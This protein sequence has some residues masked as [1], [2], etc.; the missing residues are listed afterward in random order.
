MVKAGS[1]VPANLTELGLVVLDGEVLESY[2][3]LTGV[4]E[5]KV[6]G[7]DATAAQGAAQGTLVCLGGEGG[8]RRARRLGRGGGSCGWGHPNQ[9]DVGRSGMVDA[10]S[11]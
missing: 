11:L 8:S 6:T 3:T 2:T 9:S 4:K 5:T 1:S 7:N 10:M